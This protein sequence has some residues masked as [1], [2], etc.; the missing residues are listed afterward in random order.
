MA[1][2]VIRVPLTIAVYPHFMDHCFDGRA[3]FP[4]VETLKVLAASVRDTVRI[5]GLEDNPVQLDA[6]FDKFLVVEPGV[7]T[8]PGFSDIR[9]LHDSQVTATLV[10]RMPVKNKAM[11][12]VKEHGTVGFSCQVHPVPAP[13]FRDVHDLYG[14]VTRIPADRLYRELVPFGPAFHSIQG[15][16]KVSY[17]GAAARLKARSD[18]PRDPLRNLLGSG[19]P[20]DGAFHAGCVWCQRFAGIVAFPVGFDKRVIH[21]RTREHREYEARIVPTVQGAGTFGFDIWIV[22][23]KGV[24]CETIQGVM[25]RDVSGGRIRPPDWI[26]EGRP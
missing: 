24:L 21:E 14:P 15:D 6:H 5:P 22:D 16:L 12:R 3:V 17:A 18:N 11:T 2:D 25:M 20:L 19:F 26:R 9:I 1:S 8:I 7:S 23:S 13:P 4:A 10:T